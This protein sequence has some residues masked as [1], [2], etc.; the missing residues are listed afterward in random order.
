MSARQRYRSNLR[1]YGEYRA[2]EPRKDARR[3]FI[4]VSRRRARRMG[5]ECF[6]NAASDVVGDDSYARHAKETLAY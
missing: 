2:T 4:I 5:I 1:V 6:D 3:P